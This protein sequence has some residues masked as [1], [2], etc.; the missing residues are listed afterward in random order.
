MTIDEVVRSA[1]FT[2]IANL[3]VLMEMDEN[4]VWL[5]ASLR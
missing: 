1:D 3:D 2:V 4:E 5:E